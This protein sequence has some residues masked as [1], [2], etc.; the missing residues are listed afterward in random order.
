MQLN[1]PR[2]EDQNDA[3][4]VLPFKDLNIWA[5]GKAV[6]CCEDWNEEYVVGDLRTQTLSEIWHGQPLREVRE[7]HLARRG[8][9]IALCA[10]CNSWQAPSRSA[11]LWS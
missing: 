4:C 11:K 10:K 1:A 7:K 2:R 9:D 5:D 8:H 6:L 3:P